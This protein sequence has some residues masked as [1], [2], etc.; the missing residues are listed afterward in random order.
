[1]EGA[2]HIAPRWRKIERMGKIFPLCCLIRRKEREYKS[3][4][5]GLEMEGE[6]KTNSVNNFNGKK[7]NLHDA[8][9]D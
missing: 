2:G 9:V 5:F 1:M 3:I 7:V 4:L 8:L 6:G